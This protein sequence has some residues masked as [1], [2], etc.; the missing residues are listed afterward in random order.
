[1]LA[2][3]GALTATMALVAFKIVQV[4]KAPV[5]T[6]T[7]ELVGQIGIV[8]EELAPEGIVFV[9]G[10]LWKARTD[11]DP[12]PP[13]TSV[14]VEQLDDGFVLDVEPAEPAEP[15]AAVT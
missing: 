5:V 14:R 9:R 15:A 1:V 12:I 7:S 6:G 8:R 10:E 3:A 4:R 2:I 13:G 11:G